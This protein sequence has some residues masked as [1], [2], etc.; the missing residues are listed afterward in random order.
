MS[1]KKSKVTW[2]IEIGTS[3]SNVQK[4]I[5]NFSQKMFLKIIIKK[6]SKSKI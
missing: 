5:D 2:E 3:L 4:S 1:V 6:M